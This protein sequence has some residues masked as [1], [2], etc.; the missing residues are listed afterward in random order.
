MFFLQ[1]LSCGLGLSGPTG[2]GGE[3]IVFGA[4]RLQPRQGMVQFGL[5]ALDLVP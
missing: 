3:V 4:E 2:R 5:F 1:R